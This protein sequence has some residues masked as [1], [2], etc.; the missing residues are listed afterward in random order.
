M[1]H[2]SAGSSFTAR[3]AHV[4]ASSYEEDGANRKPPL[5]LQ[6]GAWGMTTPERRGPIERNVVLFKMCHVSCNGRATLAAC[7]ACLRRVR[8][9]RNSM[10]R[11]RRAWGTHFKPVFRVVTRSLTKWETCFATQPICSVSSRVGDSTMARGRLGLLTKSCST[12]WRLS[13][14]MM[15]R[16]Y[17]SVLP[18]PV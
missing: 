2:V 5:R 18:E 10:P 17:A 14:L 16:R 9:N 7:T 15:G 6:L 13:S 3:A 8:G 1:W 12:S 4:E 11:W